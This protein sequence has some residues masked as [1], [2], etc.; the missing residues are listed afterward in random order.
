MRALTIALVFM[1][2]SACTKG[3]ANDARLMPSPPPDPKATVPKDLAIP[4][5]VGEAP[6]GT[7][8]YAKLTAT[9]PDYHDKDHLAWRIR[10]LVGPEL[11]AKARFVTLVGNRAVRMSLPFPTPESPLEPVL[12]LTRRGQIAGGLLS[13]ENP[14]PPYHGQGRRLAR[15]GDPLPRIAGPIQRITVETSTRAP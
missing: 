10:T 2:L 6:A 13:P 12:M 14:F 9:S 3:E 15:G 11:S 1:V 4:L 8:D 5:F 7:V